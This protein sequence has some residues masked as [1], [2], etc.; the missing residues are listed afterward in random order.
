MPRTIFSLQSLAGDSISHHLSGPLFTKRTGVLP[1]NLV[2]SRSR[3]FGSYDDRIALK[4]WKVI[5]QRCC[6]GTC[7]ISGQLEK[8]KPTS[9]GFETSRDLAVRRSSAQWI[10]ALVPRLEF[11][12]ECTN[13]IVASR[14]ANNRPILQI[15]QCN[16][17]IS[18]HNRNVHIVGHGTGALWDW[19]I[20]NVGTTCTI[21]PLLKFSVWDSTTVTDIIFI[22]RHQPFIHEA[23]QVSMN[24]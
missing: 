24:K 23:L 17:A 13:S 16:S 11:D 2:K 5:R 19:T 20:P 4:F 22:T 6:R 7:Q 10:E 15:S 9:H 3:E 21:L 1:P 8:P 12:Q 18:I 14:V